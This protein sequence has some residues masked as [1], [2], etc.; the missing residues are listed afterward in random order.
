MHFKALVGQLHGG[1]V[2]PSTIRADEF[3]AIY[4]CVIGHTNFSLL[5]EWY[6]KDSNA[7]PDVYILQPVS[8]KPGSQWSDVKV[9]LQELLQRGASV[10]FPRGEINKY[11]MEK[12]FISCKYIVLGFQH[13][14]CQT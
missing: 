4:T 8:S 2:P 10:A 1:C 11:Q 5:A 12:Y 7:S 6:K 14:P 13:F 9:K 3:E